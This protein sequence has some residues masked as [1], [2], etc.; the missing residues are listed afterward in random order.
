MPGQMLLCRC[1]K[2]RFQST[3]GFR[4]VCSSSIEYATASLPETE[5]NQRPVT[6]HVNGTKQHWHALST[7]LAVTDTALRINGLCVLTGQLVRCLLHHGEG[8]P[9]LP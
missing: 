2:T 3:P 8:V 5:V 7:P 4:S 1:H 6:R 9:A